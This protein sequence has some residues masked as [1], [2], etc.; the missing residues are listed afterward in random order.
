[1][2]WLDAAAGVS[3]TLTITGAVV[4]VGSMAGVFVV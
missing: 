3:S 1:V 2:G 4:E